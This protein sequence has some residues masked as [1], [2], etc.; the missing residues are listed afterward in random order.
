MNPIVFKYNLYNQTD[1]NLKIGIVDQS[2]AEIVQIDLSNRECQDFYF[3][4]VPKK[5]IVYN[6]RNPLEDIEESCNIQL[7]IDE[8]IQNYL[9]NQ[10]RMLKIVVDN[11]KG[12]SLISNVPAKGCSRV[13]PLYTIS[14]YSELAE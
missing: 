3:E 5:I 1:F 6:I 12:L 10:F 2:N 8:N 7:K 4:A 14:I 13:F 11:N 9:Y